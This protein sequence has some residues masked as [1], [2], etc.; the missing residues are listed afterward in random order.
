MVKIRDTASFTHIIFLATNIG[1][2]FG[3]KQNVISFFLYLLKKF[4]ELFVVPHHAPHQEDRGQ[5]IPR[6]QQLLSP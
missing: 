1:A 5:T 2:I 4:V 6:A 3:K